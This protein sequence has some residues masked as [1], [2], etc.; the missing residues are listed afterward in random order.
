MLSGRYDFRERVS[1]VAVSVKATE[2]TLMPG[3]DRPDA[4]PP[5][6]VSNG[7]EPESDLHSI[8]VHRETTQQ[9]YARTIKPLTEPW[10]S[11]QDG[12]CRDRKDIQSLN[13]SVSQTIIDLSFSRFIRVLPG[14]DSL[15]SP[16]V[17]L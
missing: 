15:P 6:N 13:R 14:T 1:A 8:M 10:P 3:S 17:A 5:D 4:L 2:K 16:S 7:A 12:E 11:R 9:I